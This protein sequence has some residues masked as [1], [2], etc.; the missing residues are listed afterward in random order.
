M[1]VTFKEVKGSNFTL[2]LEEST[3]VRWKCQLVA[4]CALIFL[5]E[6]ADGSLCF[7]LQISEVKE[8]IEKQ[9][10]PTYPKAHQVIVFQGKVRSARATRQPAILC[11]SPSVVCFHDLVAFASAGK[12]MRTS[13]TCRAWR[14]GARHFSPTASHLAS[15]CRY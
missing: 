13:H 9:Q 10:G 6:T 12:L 3:K 15:V 14:D 5:E 7:V 4:E 1:I 11:L 2:D 8:A